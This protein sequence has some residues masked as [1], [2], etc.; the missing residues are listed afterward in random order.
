MSLVINAGISGNNTRHLLE[1]IDR[2]VLAHRPT[3]VVLKVGTN[4]A[5][6]SRALV[7]PEEHRRN[8]DTL[9]ARL[10]PAAVLLLTPL[11][12]HAGYH[13]SRHDPAAFSDAPPAERHR[14]IIANVREVAAARRLPL[15]DL[16]AVLAGCGGAGEDAESLIRNPVN[17]GATDGVHPNAAGYR[18]IAA[19]VFAAIRAH[20]LPTAV[21]VCFGDSITFGQY[22]DG[23]G[24]AAGGTYAGVLARMLAAG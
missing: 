12:F 22:V 18:V 9:C 3:L 11:P 2:D 6:N 15:V 14:R 19:A 17:S 24:T 23:E 16:H 10:A 7:P 5:L 20:A 4:D 13:G 21:T 8:L 1:R